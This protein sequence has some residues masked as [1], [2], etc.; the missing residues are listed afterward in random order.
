LP[1][2]WRDCPV[3]SAAGETPGELISVSLVCCLHCSCLST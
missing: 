2:A 3:C 1:D